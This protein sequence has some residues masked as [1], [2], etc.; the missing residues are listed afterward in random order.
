MALIWK[1]KKNATVSE[2][3]PKKSKR[4]K[5]AKISGLATVVKESAPEPAVDLLEKNTP[6][7]LPNDV[8]WMIILINVDDETFG[9]LST[10]QK[11]DADK[12]SIIELITGDY[13]QVVQTPTMIENGVLGIVPTPSTME[14]F[15]EFG[16]LV[17]S[18]LWWGLVQETDDGGIE[19]SAVEGEVEYSTI[20]DLVEGNTTLDDAAP[21][22]WAWASEGDDSASELEDEEEDESASE[23]EDEDENESESSSET[24][25][26][27]EDTTDESDGDLEQPFGSVGNE[28]E[29]EDENEPKGIYDEEG[30]INYG[31]LDEADS[32]ENSIVYE[33]EEEDYDDYED[34]EYGV[35][36]ELYEGEDEEL[37]EDEYADSYQQYVDENR[38]RVVTIDEINDNIVRR[39]ASEDLDLQVDLD[40]FDKYFSDLAPAINLDDIPVD[41][42][43]GE[44]VADLVAQANAELAKLHDNHINN[45]RQKYIELASLH[46]ESVVKTMSTTNEDVPYYAMSIAAHEDYE[47]D[48]EEA[49][50][51]IR[52][53]RQEIL[54][55]FE[56][57][58]DQVAEAAAAAA[59]SRY[60]SQNK[61]H[62]ERLLSEVSAD[63]SRVAEDRYSQ[64][65]QTVL[66]LRRNESQ[67]LFEIGVTQIAK[68]LGEVQDENHA[69]EL[70][71]LEEW[72]DVIFEFID[73]NR[74]E[75]ISRI[76][77]LAE[78]QSRRDAV[79]E[80]KEQYRVE[81]EQLLSEQRERIA[82]LEQARE[83]ERNK[84]VAELKARDLHWETELKAANGRADRAGNLVDTISAQMMKVDESVRAQ[85]EGRIA[86]LE[87]DR[88][89]QIE[90]LNSADMLQKRANRMMVLLIVTLTLAALAV[91]VLLG[92]SL[93]ANGGGTTA[94]ASP[95][96]W[97][98]FL[99]QSLI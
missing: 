31:A 7:A 47:H 71:K 97:V 83:I 39:Y 72:N 67:S 78:Q 62:Q 61:L 58:A 16:L 88:Q 64:A 99:P 50:K 15:S 1:K 48:I 3:I 6:F 13:I 20:M 36:D 73:D 5:K 34:E 77:V 29:L 90:E 11:N 51:E 96:A 32:N 49:N 12:G 28:D 65:K 53:R 22:T 24:S 56:K 43:L 55:R 42:W 45:L 9:G 46:A 92:W 30:G 68:A 70:E 17:T 93:P 76:E 33:N 21:E 8:G 44:Q 14:R 54:D 98:N 59:K 25:V 89:R 35:P 37:D 10:K 40:V 52:E 86:T 87:A 4:G 38:S 82:E 57:E 41:G 69:A 84:A 18:Q 81:R 79:S 19:V 95:E 66:E 27:G 74:K 91:G 60:I 26:S 94:M 80:L 63:V 85:Y 23:L 75:E 2:E